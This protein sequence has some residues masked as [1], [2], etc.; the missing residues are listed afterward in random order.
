MAEVDQM[1]TDQLTSHGKIRFKRQF[2]LPLKKIH[3]VCKLGWAPWNL[4]LNWDSQQGRDLATSG[5]NKQK[6]QFGI[7][8]S[9][10]MR[11]VWYQQIWIQ[12]NLG[13]MVS[14]LM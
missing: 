3:L 6:F 14:E 13:F 11:K 12:N 1:A 5:H 8:Y 4:F 2:L 7:S 9:Y 10:I